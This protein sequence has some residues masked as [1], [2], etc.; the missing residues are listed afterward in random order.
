[1]ED[2]VIE[3]NVNHDKINA[4]QNLIQRKI[5]AM[6]ELSDQI[7]EAD[8]VIK[9]ALADNAAYNQADEKAKE[10]AKHR[11]QVRAQ[12]MDTTEM[13]NFAGKRKSLKAQKAEEKET[14]SDYLI[15]YERLTGA[16]IIESLSGVQLEI[17]KTAAVKKA[18]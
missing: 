13:K 15:D 6:E 9:G 16:N 2:T 10:A 8:E 17:F 14:L 5:Q 11:S 7:K 18:K 4:L 3:R 1:M 12:V